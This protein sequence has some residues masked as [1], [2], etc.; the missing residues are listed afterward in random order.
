MKKGG[1]L[2]G[3][4]YYVFGCR[5]GWCSLPLHHQM[6]GRWQI[7]GNQPMA[8]NPAMPELGIEKP[9][10]VTSGVFHLSSCMDCLLRFAYRHYSICK[11]TLQYVFREDFRSDTFYTTPK[12]PDLCQVKK[13]HMSFRTMKPDTSFVFCLDLTSIYSTVDHCSVRAGMPGQTLY[14]L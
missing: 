4:A 6:V 11:N 8:L 7:V 10:S 2:R 3:N 1:E 12:T 13:V 14:I 5:C 9:Q